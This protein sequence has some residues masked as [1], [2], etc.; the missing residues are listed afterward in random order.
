MKKSIV[1]T[2]DDE[3]L[4]ELEHIMLDDDCEGALLKIALKLRPKWQGICSVICL[5]AIVPL[6]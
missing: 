6:W 4:L 1:L 2:L 5:N 3:E